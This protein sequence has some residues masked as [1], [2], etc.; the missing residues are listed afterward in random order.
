MHLSFFISSSNS[1]I[2][3]VTVISSSQDGNHP[4]PSDQITMPGLPPGTVKHWILLT[5]QPVIATIFLVIA[6][7]KCYSRRGRS[8][9]K[10][11]TTAGEKREDAEAISRC[12]KYHIV[13][14][15]ER[16]SR[17]I[18]CNGARV[19]AI[20]EES[21]EGTRLQDEEH[22][23]DRTSKKTS[24]MSMLSNWTRYILT[25]QPAPLP[26][27]HRALS[28][29]STTLCVLALFMLQGFYLLFKVG[30]PPSSGDL[31]G[32]RAGLLFIN[33]LPWLY[34]FAAKNQPLKL[35][36]GFSHENMNLLHRRLGEWMCFLAVVHIGAMLMGWYEFHRP[37]GRGLIGYL[38]IPYIL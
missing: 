26:I 21:D 16:S 28:E 24:C 12:E 36:F 5:Y 10:A 17:S 23:T 1:V 34:L 20:A 6:V 29:I 8:R 14:E 15:D 3:S 19:D 38:L 30:L 31:I 37:R 11:R 13:L 35:L 32:D 18:P 4:S 33:N 25:Y 7:A 22:A 2:H 9:R 27:V